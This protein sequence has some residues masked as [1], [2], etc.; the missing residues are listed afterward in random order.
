MPDAVTTQLREYLSSMDQELGGLLEGL[1][2]HGSIA[3]GAFEPG[4]SDVDFIGVLGRRLTKDEIVG[5]TRVHR[6][7]E[8][9]YACCPLSGIYLQ[10]SELGQL[11]DAIESAPYYHD[12]ILHASG[13]ND[14]NL[15]T[16]WLLQNRGIGLRGPDPGSLAYTVDWSVLLNWVRQNLNSYWVRFTR[17][18]VRIAW[19]FTDYGVQWTVLGVLRQLYTFRE[20]GITSKT[21]AGEYGLAHLPQRWHPLI[22]EAISIRQRSIRSDYGV[23]TRR[24]AECYR[25]L[26]YI[27]PETN[28]TFDQSVKRSQVS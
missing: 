12:G 27:I 4:L 21:A 18:P 9:E 17:D 11:E 3:L 16:W 28:N 15:V 20:H 1:Y 19:L 6:A 26:K 13:H 14:I 25:F 23:G 2:V 8:E 5:L 22:Y 24:A 7:I 10:W